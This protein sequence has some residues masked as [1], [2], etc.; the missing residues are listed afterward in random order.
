MPCN[1]VTSSFFTVLSMLLNFLGFRAILREERLFSTSLLRSRLVQREEKISSYKKQTQRERRFQKL[2]LLWQSDVGHPECLCFCAFAICMFCKN[3][4]CVN[5][6]KGI[7]P[8]SGK[9]LLTW[10]CI[11]RGQL[12]WL[13]ELLVSGHDLM[14]V[15]S[16]PELGSVLSG[17]SAWDSSVSLSLFLSS[18][19]HS[20]S[21]NLR[22]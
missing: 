10:Y 22:S 13:S 6:I 3:L 8:P 14:V 5:R 4:R 11:R 16:S 18:H 9:V 1:P 19:S 2:Y 17:V 21:Q 20:L 12:S 7:S 15:R